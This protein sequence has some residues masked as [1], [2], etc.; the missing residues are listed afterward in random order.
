[1]LYS[2]IEE[3]W[4]KTPLVE[5]FGKSKEDCSAAECER[6]LSEIAKCDGCM[7]R[8]QASRPTDLIATILRNRDQIRCGLAGMALMLILIILVG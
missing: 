3:A 5:A 1:M 4:S 6:L 7:N 2:S 8:L